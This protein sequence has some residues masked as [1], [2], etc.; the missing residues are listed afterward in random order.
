MISKI[1]RKTGKKKRSISVKKNLRAKRFTRLQRN[2]LMNEFDESKIGIKLNNQIRTEN[3][4]FEQ[5]QREQSTG[6]EPKAA[7]L[8]LSVREK[9]WRY[10]DELIK[11]ARKQGAYSSTLKFFEK[12]KNKTDF[13][14]IKQ[15]LN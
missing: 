8:W 10:Y 14:K 9:Y 12:Q 7:V 6:W 1:Q 5:I 15:A 3:L 2:R 13:G 11:F 4:L